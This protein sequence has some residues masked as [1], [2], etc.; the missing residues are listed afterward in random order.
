MRTPVRTEPAPTI[1]RDTYTD[2][3]LRPLVSTFLRYGVLIA[4]LVIL[5]GLIMLLIQ[6]GPSAF[7][8]M[9]QIRGAEPGTDLTSLRAVVRGLVPPEPEAV[10]DIGVLLLVTTPVLTVGAAMISFALEADWLYVAISGFVLAILLLAFA[11]GRSM[12]AG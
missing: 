4:A 9:P 11:L 7:V 6:V 3:A 8:Y 5:L 10:M 12:S 2:A 1:S